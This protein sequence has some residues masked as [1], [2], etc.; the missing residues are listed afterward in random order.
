MCHMLLLQKLG[1]SDAL[2]GWS[3]A[4]LCAAVLEELS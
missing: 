3:Q 2:L 1:G 4:W